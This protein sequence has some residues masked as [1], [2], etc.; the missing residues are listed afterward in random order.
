M[1]FNEYDFFCEITVVV[2]HMTETGEGTKTDKQRELV[3]AITYCNWLSEKKAF[4]K[5]YDSNG[6]LLDKYGR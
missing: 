4:Q 1:T 5:A 2:S 6:N 3:D